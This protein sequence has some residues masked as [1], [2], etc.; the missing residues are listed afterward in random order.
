MNDAEALGQCAWTFQVTVDEGSS[1]LLTNVA[2]HSNDQL[3]TVEEGAVAVVTLP[4]SVKN[5][6]IPL[7]FK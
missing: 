1:G 7:L 3:G 4:A 6:Y 2:M 5:I